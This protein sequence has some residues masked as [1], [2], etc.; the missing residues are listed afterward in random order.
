MAPTAEGH[1]TG[2]A[3]AAI[4]GVTDALVRAAHELD[5]TPA[6]EFDCQI[7]GVND[8]AGFTTVRG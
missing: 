4:D 7:A 3:A 5:T 1:W 8:L 6:G 2:G